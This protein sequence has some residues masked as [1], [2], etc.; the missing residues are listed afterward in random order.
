MFFLKTSQRDE[1]FH[2]REQARLIEHGSWEGEHWARKRSGEE[3][4]VW[5][6]LSAVRGPD[7][8]ITHIAAVLSDISER[9]RYE[10]HLEH[11]ARHDPL[12]GLPNRQYLLA[13]LERETG[14][15][16]VGKVAL[17]VLFIDLDRFKIVNDTLGH[18]V[19]DELLCAVAH[20][21][22]ACLDERHVLA[23]LG[24]D[25]FTV[26]APF[27]GKNGVET[28]ARRLVA[29]M[30]DPFV[31]ASYELMVTASVGIS[32]CPRD[33]ARPAELLM[34]AD[35]AMYRAKERGR[36]NFQFYEP[37]MGLR[38]QRLHLLERELRHALTGQQLMLHYQPKVELA[39]GRCVGMEALIRWEHPGL[40][41]V[42]PAEFIPVAEE[43]GA[44]VP[45][46]ELALREAC[47]QV[48]AWRALGRECSVAV[49]LSSRQLRQ[50]D[51]ASS[52]LRV[53][54][55]AGAPC[56]LIELEITHALN[57]EVVAEGVEDAAQVDFLRQQGCDTAQGYFF[58]RPVPAVAATRMLL[59]HG[60]SR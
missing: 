9:K 45:I 32:L 34:R 48:A 54:D 52:I 44:I 31:V 42:S 46:G 39:S 47:R 60:I 49:N 17:A 53:I 7:E 5:L 12:T 14:V 22:R 59:Q 8:R 37:S 33:G 57:L 3:F 41:A 6:S 29:S 11:L 26:I 10:A 50:P 2:R 56:E 13:T 27:E 35:N 25:E 40:G 38:A 18:A 21:L 51:L 20:R 23:R 30:V 58:G 55:E 19:G 28:L 4:P 16:A 15:A 1:A 43:I 24:G 36:N